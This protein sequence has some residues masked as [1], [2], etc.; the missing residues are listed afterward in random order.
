MYAMISRFL[1]SSGFLAQ[2]WGF[3]ADFWG[4]LADFWL[5]LLIFSV[6]NGDF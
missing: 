1:V 2:P 6:K 5:I 3:L 4:F